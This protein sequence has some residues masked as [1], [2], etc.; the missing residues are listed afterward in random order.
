MAEEAKDLSQAPQ[1]PAMLSLQGLTRLRAAMGNAERQ[2][3]AGRRLTLQELGEYMQVPPQTLKTVLK[4]QTGVDLRTL[5]QCFTAFQLPLQPSDL[6]SLPMPAQRAESQ[7]KISRQVP[8]IDWSTAPDGAPF[9][10]RRR[11]L[12]QLARWI[13][14][15]G[16]RSVAILGLGGVGKTSLVAHLAHRL[17]PRFNAVIWRSLR[18]APPPEILLNDLVMFLSNHQNLEPSLSSLMQQLR[19]QRCLVLLDNFDTVLQTGSNAGRY[20]PGYEAY[21]ELLHTI[22]AANHQSCLLFTSRE[23]P[24][25][26]AL[27]AGSKDPVRLL[28]LTGS[29]EVTEGILQAKQ[30]TGTEAQRQALSQ[31]YDHNPLVLQI[32]AASIHDVFGGNLG[33]F[34]AQEVRV[35]NGVRRLLEQQFN[36]LSE[37]ERS[38]SIWLAINREGARVDE[39]VADLIPAASSA[40]VVQA[41]ESLRWRSLVEQQGD[42]YSQQPVIMEYVLDQVLELMYGELTGI[43]PLPPLS[44]VQALA[45]Q[46]LPVFSRYALVK[47]TVRDYIRQSQ[48]RLILQPLA[49]RL[50]QSFTD[51]DALEN[52]IQMFLGQLRPLEQWTQQGYGTGNCIDLLSYLKVDLTGYDFS[53][54]PIWQAYLQATPLHRVKFSGAFF[55]QSRFADVFGIVLG[56]AFSPDGQHLAVGDSSGLVRLHRTA[57]LQTQRL[58]EG[59][60]SRVM[61][62]AWSANGQYLASASM[63]CTVRLW[64]ALTGQAMAILHGHQNLVM[65]VSWHPT[66][67]LLATGSEDHTVHLWDVATGSLHQVWRGHS[68]SVRSVSWS[69]DGQLL[70]SAGADGLLRLWDLTT[71]ESEVLTGHRDSLWAVDWSPDG[72]WLASGGEDGTVRIWQ[73]RGEHSSRV[74]TGHSEW[75]WSLRFSPDGQRL[76]SGSRDRTIRLWDVATGTT[77]KVLKAHPMGVSALGWHPQQALLASGG[78]DQAI[79]LWDTRSGHSLM[80]LQGFTTSVWSVAWNPR[81]GLAADLPELASGHQDGS[82]W[83]WRR[84]SGVPLRRLYGH[85]RQVWQVAWSPQGQALASCGDDGTVQ[86]WNSSTGEQQ[87]ILRGHRHDRVWTVTW[88]PDASLLASGG[89][90][91]AIYLWDALTGAQ[92]K[93]WQAHGSDVMTLQFSPD[94][95][96]LASGSED[97]S[98]RLWNLKTGQLELTLEGHTDRITQLQ[99]SPDGTW[100]A[101]AS[102][103]RSIRLWQLPS[104]QCLNSLLGH[105]NRVWGIQFSPDGQRL[106][107]G[108]TDRTVR[109]WDLGTGTCEAVLRDHESL[110]WS[111]GWSADGQTLASGGEDGLIKLWSLPNQRLIATLRGDRLYEGMQIQGATGLSQAAIAGLQKLGASVTF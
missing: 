47:T 70:A 39:L 60:G 106:V 93:T 38:I 97:K 46:P 61:S 56:L 57:D 64:N 105:N 19:A 11:E 34:L 94:G 27:A 8:R 111:V 67:T 90:D 84:G 51:L 4:R 101:S 98:L 82:V 17:A 77:T 102:E 103:D 66:G 21:G 58:F 29:A 12:E 85:A 23:K 25:E 49:E 68:D 14:L 74:L 75:V 109:L 3:F 32:V 107:S 15:E 9:Y 80:F 88:S 6:E 45:M 96:W 62:V 71:G 78:V 59:H 44:T 24:L 20:R 86:L 73:S 43:I 13:Q 31:H 1:Q 89:A 55:R 69:P 110:L 18:Q 52:Q 53:G 99:F 108:S 83:L 42:R 91:A 30:L 65:S 79:R 41:L 2:Q 22:G 104:G 5:E 63:D 10:G 28:T 16:C 33:S 92:L 54:L 87:A 36:R 50:R 72:Q 7:A 26:M 40:A 95:Q 100:L 76:A 35:F 81:V 37:L 48:V